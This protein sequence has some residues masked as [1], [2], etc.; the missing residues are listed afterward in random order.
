MLAPEVRRLVNMGK[1]VRHSSYQF[2]KRLDN[3]L[4]RG[5]MK[6]LEVY[7]VPQSAVLRPIEQGEKRMRHPR[8]N[9]WIVCNVCAS[10]SDRIYSRVGESLV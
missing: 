8:T 6:S 5:C 7:K 4:S 3:M 1:A 10:V 9:R 2:L